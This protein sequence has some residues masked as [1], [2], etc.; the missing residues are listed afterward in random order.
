RA[1]NQAG[2]KITQGTTNY[3]EGQDY[4]GATA[5]QF[6]SQSEIQVMLNEE[7]TAKL[8]F[9]E[10]LNTGDKSVSGRVFVDINQDGD[11]N[12]NDFALEG[13]AIQLSG[14]DLY[15]EVVELSMVTDA[16]GAFNFTDLRASNQA[17]YK[18]TQ[19]T[20]D[21]LEGQD[22]LGATPDQFGS[23]S[24]IQLILTKDMLQTEEAIFTEQLHA[25]SEIQGLVYADSNTNGIWSVDETGLSGVTVTLSGM[26]KYGDDLQ[27][28]TLTND[29]GIFT[30]TNLVAS[31]DSGYLIT[32]QQPAGF[33]DGEESLNGTV[34][35]NSNDMFTVRL[36]TNEQVMGYH[37][38]ELYQGSIS[39][40]VFVDTNEDGLLSDHDEPIN[41]SVISLTGRN[42]IGQKI[43]LNIT[44]NSA[45][46]FEFTQLPESDEQGYTLTQ[47]QPEFYVDGYE[48]QSGTLITGSNQSDEISGLVLAQGDELVAQNFTEGFGIAV[49]GRVFVDPNDSGIYSGVAENAIADN[50]IILTGRDHRGN[51]VEHSALTNELG[52]YLFTQLP[53]SNSD[54]YV[55]SQ[56]QQPDTYLDGRE[57]NS[58]VVLANSKGSD[59]IAIGVVRELKQYGNFDFAEL[60]KASLRGTVWVDA[61]EDGILENDETLRVSAAEVSLSGVTLDGE[62][63][64]RTVLTN[65]LGVFEFGALYPGTYQ[66]QQIQPSAWLD[67][68]EQ[69]G[70][71][72]GTIGE[73]LF[74]G[75]EIALAQ[76]AAGYNFAERGSDLAGRVYVDLND[77]GTQDTYE[78]GLSSVKLLIEG[79]DLDNQPVK[80][81]ILTDAY[82]RYEFVDLP[83]SAESGFTITEFQP[84]NTQDGLD[85]VGSIG[86][87]LGEDQISQIHIER[88]VTKAHS[89]NFGEQLMDPASISGLV[90]LDK[91][92]NREK[93][94]NNGQRGWLVELLPDPMTG[95][96]N[97][98][99]AEPLAAVQSDENGEYIFQGL[100]VGTYEIRFRHPKGGVIY[101]LP[102]SDDPDASTEKGTILNL[103]VSAGENV[104][105]QSL[106][107]DPSG[108][109][110]DSKLRLPIIGA[111]IKITGPQGFEPEFHLVGGEANVEQ[112]TSDDGYY[113]FLLFAQ[114]PAGVYELHVTAPNGYK[115]QGSELLPV[116][117]NTLRVGARDLPITIYAEE[118]VPTLDAP[119]HDADQCAEHSDQALQDM[120]TTQYYQRFYIEPKL[121]S[122]NVVNNHI[123]LDAFG[124]DLVSVSK[125]ALKQDVVVGE[126]VPYRIKLTNQSEQ[127][128]A[129]LAFVDQLPAGLKYVAGSAKVDGLP[130]EPVLNGRQLSWRGKSLHPQQ[131]VSIELLAVVGSGVSEGKYINQAWVEFVGGLYQSGSGNRISNIG[132]AAVQVVPD[133]I[134]DCSDLTGQVFDDSNRN[135]IQDSDEQGLPAVRLATAQGLWI[136]TDQY[137]RYHLACA[138]IPHS[139]RGSNF[140]VK[141]DERS[142]PSG[143]R[144]I[145]ENPRVVRLTRGKSQQL[146]FAASIHRVARIEV[147]KQLFSNSDIQVEYQQQMLQ[148]MQALDQ[149]PTILRVAYQ[150]S[151]QEQST[152][153]EQKLETLITWLQEQAAQYALPITLETE[154]IPFYIP[155]LPAKKQA[156]V[157]SD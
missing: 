103:R 144:V 8:T 61:D 36:G 156:G 56:R 133:P 18:I 78:I 157:S 100:P 122:G 102:V 106:P 81:E 92:H 82:G 15:G 127:S 49:G 48:Y 14:L 150:L 31:N 2:Y 1:S 54:G 149:T 110:Y 40:A 39:G 77:N 101:G 98:L 53:P 41:S 96:G 9:T 52:V 99:D 32:Q 80:R 19:G 138:D 71:G 89:Y 35:P 62:I 17:G 114:A 58:G 64:E 75:I 11:P 24:E 124:D 33:K 121:P 10:Q 86:G 65:E 137:G 142:L 128:L 85:S 5:D 63:I 119:I 132:T 126:L 152:A 94:D 55:V 7:A 97:P 74:T 27:V 59:A 42:S 22:Y 140:I 68:K 116:C 44:T 147:T 26:T 73:D 120:H 107:V 72:G 130:Q 30:F 12:G 79:A 69:L 117:N 155:A 151:E 20:T 111:K 95:E 91:N 112:T 113:Q 108:V 70:D 93:D 66:I 131:V 57:S 109:I 154:M 76:H 129:P 153:A 60:P 87:V 37:F 135:G 146:D 134:F 16:K 38:A 4:V 145:T 43:E 34:I 29:Q 46:L 23:Q 105:N 143:Y 28:E 104:Q 3:L 88:H 148:L 50:E 51:L 21:Y 83:L 136:T 67:G 125:Q 118:T 45:G 13:I 25:G 6:G 123:P 47:I 139:V 90:W 115:P 141:L 84:E